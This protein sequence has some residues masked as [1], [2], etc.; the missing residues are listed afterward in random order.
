MVLAQVV[1]DH[2]GIF[3]SDLRAQTSIPADLI[4]IAIARHDLYVD[5]ATYR[6]SEPWYTPVFLTRQAARTF[7]LPKSQGGKGGG[8]S[9]F[10][11]TPE[12]FTAE[13]QAL[14]EQASEADLATALFRNRVIHPKDYQDDEQAQTAARRAA[15]PD[16]T[17]QYWQQLYREGEARY[18]SGFL[19][20]LPHYHNCGGLRQIKAEVIALIHQVLETHY[21][22]TTRKPKRGAYGEYLKCSEEQHLN[23]VSQ[24]TFYLEAKRHLGAYDQ[25][26]IR[27]GMRAAYP[28]KDFVREQER[29]ISRH[30]SY[31]WAMGHLDHTELNLVLCD[32]RTGEPLGKCWLTLLILSHPRRIASY[33]LTFDPPSYRSCMMA[34]RLCVQR[35]GRLPTA[36]T[37]DGGPEFASVYF[38]QLLAL[39]RVR[40]HQRPAAEPRFGAPQERLFGSMQSEFLYHLLGNT[41]ATQQPRLNTRATDPQ[42][43]AVWTLPALAERVQRWADEEYETIRHP[44]LGMT[45]RRAYDLSIE[46]DG[47]RSHRDISYDEA[48]RMATLP[49]TRK[50]M[51]KVVPGVGVRMN[52]LDYWCE[53]MRDATIENTQVQV[54]F[55]PFDVSVGFVYIDG[56]WRQCFTP[57]DEFAGCSERE[58]QLLASELRQNNRLQYGREQV[59]ITQKQLADFR[60]QNAAK[61]AILRQQRTDRETRAALKVLE[62]GKRAAATSDAS[63]AADKP[64]RPAV[65]PAPQEKKPDKLL[66]FKRIRP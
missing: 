2:P 8:T 17:R 44:A 45:P 18:G 22:T 46:R 23:A 15:V 43:L 20:L 7:S 21:D 47:Q 57:Y 58:L 49:T 27:E 61:E 40:K 32:S 19:G 13:G 31:C 11:V 4:N 51:A 54:R 56:V 10:S 55:D 30:G 36:I 42:R 41:Q 48:F 63:P 29:T 28:F 35:Y 60:R 52:H 37:V 1:K 5:A 38:E 16:R 65:L 9:P 64:A 39:Y 50:G 62:G 25:T 66:V 34:L 59:E 33:Y 12:N 53:V 24:K 3:L 6:L 26:V 14:L